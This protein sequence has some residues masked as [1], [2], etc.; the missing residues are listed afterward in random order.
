MARV[1]LPLTRNS[2]TF[3]AGI[4]RGAGIPKGQDARRYDKTLE[5]TIWGWHTENSTLQAIFEINDEVDWE[6]KYRPSLEAMRNS[7]LDLFASLARLK[8]EEIILKAGSPKIAR[9]VRFLVRHRQP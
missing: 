3:P 6:P 9:K 4:L 7:L 2:A 5:S 8:D 1:G